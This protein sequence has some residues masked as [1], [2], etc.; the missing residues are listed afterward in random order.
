MIYNLATEFCLRQK[1][2]QLLFFN[3]YGTLANSREPDD[4]ELP[5]PTEC[6]YCRKDLGKTF[7]INDE[8]RSDVDDDD[9]D[10]DDAAGGKNEGGVIKGYCHD[11]CLRCGQKRC[12]I[13]GCIGTARWSLWLRVQSPK[14]RESGRYLIPIVMC[15]AHKEGNEKTIGINDAMWQYLSGIES[16]M[17][18]KVQRGD[19][20]LEFDRIKEE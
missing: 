15:H 12:I 19:C 6:L 18:A 7:S 11:A 5:M 4:V 8:K 2:G 10:D 14:A 3:S 17:R 20:Q 13:K 9:D 1:D 16:L